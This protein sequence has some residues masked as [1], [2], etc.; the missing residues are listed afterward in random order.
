MAESTSEARPA[1]ANR[2][3]AEREARGWSQAAA[4]R[5]LRAHSEVSLPNDQAMLRNWRRW[6]SGKNQPDEFYAPLIAATFSTVTDAFFPPARDHSSDLIVATGLDTLEI[7]SRLHVSDLTPAAM[8]ALWITV[9]RLCSEYPYMPPAQLQAEARQWLRR[10]TALLDGRLTLT[11]HRDVLVVSGWLALLL[12]C[13]EYDLGKR[14]S[15]EA[16]RKAAL[17]LGKEAENTEILG[18]AAEMSA[19]FALTEANYRGVIAAVDNV[20]SLAHTGVGAQLT[21]QRAKAWARIGDRRQVEVALDSGRRILEHLTHPTNLDNHFVVDP[22]KFDFY[23]M[24]CYRLVDEP[25]MAA[26]YADEVIRSSTAP[27]GTLRK[28]MRAAEAQIT[29]GVIAARQGDLDSAVGHG[30]LALSGDRFSL[31]SLTMV[32]TELVDVLKARYP[33]ENATHD[34]AERFRELTSSTPK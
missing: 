5:A 8:D 29:L 4:I 31:P 30:T 9:D 1:W 2:M 10:V 14:N 15:A 6:E 22:G 27:D 7:V 19:W 13:V 33:H 3:K 25:K 24:D 34:F 11:Q 23:A 18:W 16:T 21:A 32:G 28:P 20:P 26:L 12:G 17:S